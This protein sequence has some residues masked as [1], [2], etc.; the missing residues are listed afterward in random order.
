M[1][2]VGMGAWGNDIKALQEMLN[3]WGYRIKINGIFGEATK[4]AVMH[5]QRTHYDDSGAPLIVDGFVNPKTW[6]AL[7]YVVRI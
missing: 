1:R 4:T 3:M 5:F 2:N 7:A 6:R